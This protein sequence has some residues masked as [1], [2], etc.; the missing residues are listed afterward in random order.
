MTI[1]EVVELAVL[2]VAFLLQAFAGGHQ[3]VAVDLVDPELRIHIGEAPELEGQGALDR[4]LAELFLAFADSNFHRVFVQRLLPGLVH[5]HA[6]VAAG[7]EFLHH[8]TQRRGALAVGAQALG[9]GGPVFGGGAADDG[10]NRVLPDQNHF[11]LIHVG[12]RR[13]SD[14]GQEQGQ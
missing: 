3:A 12:K 5:Q 8:A 1:V 7:G 9:A 13:G 11:D 2:G 10:G 4:E 14:Q 6:V